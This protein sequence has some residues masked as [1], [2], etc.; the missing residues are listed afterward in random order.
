MQV[1]ITFIA[2]NLTLMYLLYKIVLVF[3]DCA[4]FTELYLFYKIA[5]N[6]PLDAH[7]GGKK[8]V[9]KVDLYVKKWYNNSVLKK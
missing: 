6:F 5:F 1:L 8:I 9:K 7:F 2:F 3:H 4:C